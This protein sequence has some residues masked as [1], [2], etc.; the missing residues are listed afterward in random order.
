MFCYWTFAGMTCDLE[1]QRL[2]T[3]AWVALST[4]QGSGEF[5]SVVKEFQQDLTSR[6]V[7]RNWRNN[8]RCLPRY[9]RR[10]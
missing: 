1:I 10:V 4:A 3:M 8:W 5:K 6:L 9:A 2:G 7:N